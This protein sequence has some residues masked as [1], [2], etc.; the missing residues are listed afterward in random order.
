MIFE[1][2]SNPAFALQIPETV[3]IA[4]EAVSDGMCVVI[5]LQSTGEA[6]TNTVLGQLGG[7]QMDD[8]I[9]APQQILLAWLH[10]YFPTTSGGLTESQ[11]AGLYTMVSPFSSR[12]ELL[13][14]SS[15]RPGTSVSKTLSVRGQNGSQDFITDDPPTLQ[16][17]VISSAT[18][19]R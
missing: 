9:S 14:K 3:R 11:L 15:C 4:L 13:C 5:G 16:N 12:K 19:L 1:L 10:N 2:F 7:D 18:L 17:M 8:F 6:N